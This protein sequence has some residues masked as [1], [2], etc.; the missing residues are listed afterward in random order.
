MGRIAHSGLAFTRLLTVAVLLWT[1]GVTMALAM[2]QDPAPPAAR[3]SVYRNAVLIDG[4]GADARPGMSIVIADDRIQA[5][6]PDADITPPDGAEIIDAGGLYVLPGLIDTHVHLG[7]DPSRAWAEATL[8]RLLYSGV[9][10]VRDMAGDARFLAELQR[11]V[12]VGEVPGPDLYYVALMAGPSFF[13]DPRT[14]AAARGT[15]PGQAAWMQAVDADTDMALAV[16]RAR[17]TGA[18]AIKIYANLDGQTVHRIIEEA[19]RQDFPVWAHGMLF[20][21]LPADIVAAGPEV[22]SHVCYLGYQ[23]PP[24]PANYHERTG[25][26]V[27]LFEAGIPTEITTLFDQMHESGIVLDATARIYAPGPGGDAPGSWRCEGDL[28]FRLINEAWR[29]G[30]MIS[31]GTDGDTAWDHP[32]PALHEELELLTDRAGLPPMEAIRAATAVAAR[33]VNQEDQ[34]G[35]IEPGKLANLVFVHDDP[36]ADVSNL[37]SV[38]F[39]VRRGVAYQR[40]DYVP[41]T[42]EEM[43]EIGS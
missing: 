18:T 5:V 42:E 25:V 4:T 24:R 14:H 12:L 28:A 1:G 31:A 7:T 35:T 3:I 2:A 15:T 40:E 16:A 8:R 39:T 9:T 38:A 13:I 22:I 20:P 41:V 26:D 43:A 29:R 21:G 6:A 10:A 23:L 34:M 33:A 30:V 32:Y 37:R 27:S 11:Q 36:L 19:H 17:G